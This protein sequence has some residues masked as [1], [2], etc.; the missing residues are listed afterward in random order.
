MSEASIEK[1]TETVYAMDGHGVLR[2]ADGQET[3]FVAVQVAH[4]ERV[5]KAV[6]HLDMCPVCW[7]VEGDHWTDRKQQCPFRLFATMIP[8][9]IETQGP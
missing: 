3:G 2:T 7:K 6:A 1:E 9:T 8:Q 4:L 5:V